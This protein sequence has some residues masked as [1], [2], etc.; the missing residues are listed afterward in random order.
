M[1]SNLESEVCSVELTLEHEAIPRREPLTQRLY[2]VG[3]IHGCSR[4]LDDVLDRIARDLAIQPVAAATEIYIGDYVDRGSDSHGVLERLIRRRDA[5]QAVCLAGNHEQLILA[6]LERPE[7][8]LRWLRLGG[9][10]T[11]ISYGIT[12]PRQLADDMA[13]AFLAFRKRFPEKHRSFLHSLPLLH[14]HGRFLFVHAGIR[15][16]IALE[17]QSAADLTTIRTAFLDF[18][19]QHESYVVHG[20]TPVAQVD[21]RANRVNIDTGAFATGRLSCIVIDG[22]AVREL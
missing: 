17:R 21:F 10:E 12:P 8:F 5:G 4:L 6:A 20:H 1:S 18:E 3:D 15:P 13:R 16:G 7:A 14:R 2:V 19:G 22:T 9:R 11:L